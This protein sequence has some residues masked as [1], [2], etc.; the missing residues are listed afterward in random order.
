MET[1]ARDSPFLFVGN[2]LCLDFINT[3]IMLHGQQV[4][5]ISTYADL[6][7]WMLEA[8]GREA[9]PP[10]TIEASWS[11]EVKEQIV[12]QALALR[13]TLRSIVEQITAGQ[14]V[15]DQNINAINDWLKQRKGYQ[16]LSCTEDGYAAA[17]CYEE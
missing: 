5:L 14:V 7:E 17:V 16:K 2:Y 12:R 3:E 8:R 13:A 9:V 11:G 10:D 6:R 15:S 1:E 4:S